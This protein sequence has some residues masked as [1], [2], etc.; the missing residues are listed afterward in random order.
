M[1]SFREKSEQ[2]LLAGISFSEEGIAL[3]LVNH[4]L[5]T[6]KLEFCQFYPCFANQ[7]EETLRQLVKTHQLNSVPCNF[8]LQP[9][10]YQLLQVDTPEV[11]KQELTAALRW[12]IKDLIDFHVDDAVIEH[13]SLPDQGTSGKNQLLVIASRSSVIQSHVDTF[14]AANCQLSTIDI[15]I[16]AARNIINRVS[17]AETSIG[18]LNL[19]NGLSKISVIL[20][21]DIYINRTS[22]I[23]LESLNFVSEDDYN[24]QSILDSLALELQRTFDYYESHARQASLTH[25]FILSNGPEINNIDQLLQQRLGIDCF[26]IDILDILPTNS[27]AKNTIDNRCL[28]A[29]GGALRSSI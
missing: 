14:Q 26:N 27:S 9:E 22:S 23:G 18:V 11:P 21:Q 12:Q 7:Q 29:I 28:S 4:S 13:I 15:A 24:S 19:W 16:Q 20:N 3:A 10:E 1:F 8:I 17:T 25:L 2:G 6:V 5:N